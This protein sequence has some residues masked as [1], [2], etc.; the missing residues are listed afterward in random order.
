M[1]VDPQTYVAYYCDYFDKKGR[2]WQFHNYTFSWIKNGT[3][4]ETNMIM[5]DVQRRHSS[6]TYLDNFGNHYD[7]PHI[8]PDFYVMDKLR[9]YFG[10]R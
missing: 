5:V 9:R 10:G 2:V 6:N 3:F 4:E 1:Y 8:R 7:V